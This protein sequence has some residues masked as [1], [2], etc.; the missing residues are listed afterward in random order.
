MITAVLV[1]ACQVTVN[2]VNRLLIG[3]ISDFPQVELGA[4]TFLTG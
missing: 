1:S 4:G 2:L 3:M